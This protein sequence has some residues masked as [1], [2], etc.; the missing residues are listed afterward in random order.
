M[1]YLL[2]YLEGLKMS[3]VTYG[4]TANTKVL[5]TEGFRGW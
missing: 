5:T 4:I 1:N 3:K 2:V